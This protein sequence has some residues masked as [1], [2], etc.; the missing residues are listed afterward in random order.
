M[1]DPVL[2]RGDIEFDLARIL[3][4]SIDAMSSD[5][6][7]LDHF[8]TLVATAGLDRDRARDW[9]V[10]RTIDYWLW[11]LGAGLT[12]DPVRCHRVLRRFL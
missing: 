11:G 1:V 3:W 2:Y 9:V 12:E 7:L 8:G 10:F 6:E 5:D 4:T